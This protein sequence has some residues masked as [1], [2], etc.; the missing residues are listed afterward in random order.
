M[1]T[2]GATFMKLDWLNHAATA[3]VCSNCN[4]IE[5]FYNAP[6]ALQ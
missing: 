1:N 3:L 5:W 4:R 2:R 6:A